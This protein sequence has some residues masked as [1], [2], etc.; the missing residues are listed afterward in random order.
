MPRHFL[1]RILPSER[2]R[3]AALFGIAALLPSVDLGDQRSAVWQTPVKTL[4]IKDTDF[5]FSHVEP[6]GVFW[7][8]VKGNAPQQ[9]F[10]LLDSKHVLEALAEVGIEVVHDQ[11]DA[12]RRAIDLF[13][14]ILDESHEVGLGAVVG[15]HDSSPSAL[16]FDRHKQIA[17][18]GTH[19]LVILPHRHSGTDGQ[20]RAGVLEQLLALLVQANNRFLRP[21]WTRVEVEQIVHPL[22]IL[23][24]Q[25]SDAP[26]QLAPR[27][28][29]VF[30]SSRRTV[31]R[32]MGPTP[33]CACAACSSKASVQRWAPAGGSE[34][35]KAATCASTSVSYFRGLPG[36][37][38]SCTAYSTPPSRYATRV[39]QMTVRPTPRTAMICA[40][41]IPRSS[42]E[43]TCARLTSRAW[44]KPFARYDS[45]NSRSSSVRC[46]SVCR[47]ANSSSWDGYA[48]A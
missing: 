34:Q 48:T 22:S 15:D 7:G 36:R 33:A 26:H 16:G 41:G 13:E 40:S 45:I 5:D 27:L 21:E 20:R 1:I 19:I 23:L 4:A 32:L 3:D 9:R 31:S 11:M 42:A 14:Q 44:C 35:A 24:C 10:R 8:V 17:G 46:N 28:D 37:S 18:T 29:A 39:R 38:T 30:F 2:P 6:A 43:S 47:M 25:S 12:A